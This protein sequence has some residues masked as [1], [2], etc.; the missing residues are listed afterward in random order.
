MTLRH[1]RIFIEVYRE[2]NMTHAAE[3]LHMAQPAVSRSIQEMERYYGVRLFER[4]GRRLCATECG[5]EL[6]G[7]ALHIDEAFSE[8]EKRLLN[9]DTSGALRVGATI[10]IGNRELPGIV[11]AFEQVR[12]AMKVK[13]K[14]ANAELLKAAL[15]YGELDLALTEG[16]SMPPELLS[17]PFGSDRLILIM[18]VGSPLA[19][20]RVITLDDV[21]MQPLLLREKGSACR[22]M[23]DRLLEEHG[24]SVE[25]AWESASTQALVCA[26]EAGLGVAL[27]P[28]AL[29]IDDV[30]AGRVCAGNIEGVALMR[31]YSIVWHKH[32]YI[33]P[34][35]RLF[36][37]ICLAQNMPSSD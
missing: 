36:M 12:P 26:V 5:R 20:Q 15:I 23:V 13:V 31:E 34:A 17:Q 25:P 1:M 6:Y 9:W 28:E 37:D 10:A 16:A 8:M 7:Y 4:L 3:K 35:A 14:I 32:K 24:Q 30:K 18:P 11:R 33:T 19:A 27:L 22:A 29:T 21:L 2:L